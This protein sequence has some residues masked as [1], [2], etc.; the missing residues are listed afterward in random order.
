MKKLLIIILI[1]VFGCSQS[2][3]VKNAILFANVSNFKSSQIIENQLINYSYL[4]ES[5][6]NYLVL[7]N[8]RNESVIQIID[9]FTGITLF[10]GINFGDG[11]QEILVPISI[12]IDKKTGEVSIQD[13]GTNTI[14]SFNFEELENSNFESI[15]MHTE[16]LPTTGDRIYP[17][18]PLK[19][20]LIGVTLDKEMEIITF[21]N[22]EIYDT[23]FM[24]S[25]PTQFNH[26]P[27]KFYGI[28][29]EG[30]FGISEDK[31]YLLKGNLYQQIITIYNL[32]TR[33]FK[34]F[35]NEDEFE[36]TDEFIETTGRFKWDPNRSFQYASVKEKN[37]KFYLLYSGV[38]IKSDEI[39]LLG[40]EIHVFD[41]KS[42]TFE[43]I[44]LDSPISDF[45][46]SD[47]NIIYGINFTSNTPVIS[48]FPN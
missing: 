29:L 33:T 37:G 48:F 44:I 20:L 4:I 36:Y 1:L 47:D 6:K 3:K 18:Y 5:Y 25:Q 17:T 14:K 35:K 31:K 41:L 22:S 13:G 24:Y 27:Q 32:E 15:I 16:K 43:R 21:K 7:L 10:K 42:E 34:E 2:N 19:N 45:T 12:Y 46:I 39:V 9:R 23:L 40:K 8:F 11:P 28:Q 38:N 30:K 26:L